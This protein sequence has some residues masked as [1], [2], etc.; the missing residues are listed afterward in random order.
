[1]IQSPPAGTS[2]S[3]YQSIFDN[4]LDA[5]RK[6][7]RNDIVSHPLLTKIES[8]D[9]PE[10]ILTTLQGEILGFD[11]VPSSNYKSTTRLSSTVK[12]LHAFSST[13]SECFSLVSLR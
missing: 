3:S 7:T 10:A 2:S 1:M 11:Q 12:V 6:K 9:S 5:Y 8:C 4:A 13:I